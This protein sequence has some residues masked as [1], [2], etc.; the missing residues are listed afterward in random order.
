MIQ[1][2]WTRTLKSASLG[3]Q[4]V[5]QQ[6]GH[7]SVSIQLNSA[8]P[9][10]SAQYDATPVD[11]AQHKAALPWAPN[12][13]TAD[14]TMNRRSTITFSLEA[15]K[16]FQGLLCSNIPAFAG[17]FAEQRWELCRT[18]DV[19]SSGQML[20]RLAAW[21]WNPEVEDGSIRS[22]GKALKALKAPEERQE[23]NLRYLGS[24]GDH[25]IRSGS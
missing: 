19:F 7:D 14:R 1:A 21:I 8:T 13:A 24:R 6:V 15:P 4:K 22:C 12:S 2:C 10:E 20:K 17:S 3:Y 9:D 18:A 5:G 11:H 23:E 25:E 16:A